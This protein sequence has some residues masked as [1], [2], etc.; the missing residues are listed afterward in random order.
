MPEGLN[1]DQEA[2]N[3]AYELHSS[4]KVGLGESAGLLPDLS[5]IGCS[6]IDKVVA[7]GEKLYSQIKISGDAG[8][9]L[10]NW[11]SEAKKKQ[12]DC[13]ALI[14][15]IPKKKLSKNLF[16]IVIL[17][18]AVVAGIIVSKIFYNEK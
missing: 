9:Q 16:P 2:L 7:N 1:I 15:P 6:S 18:G 13:K 11:M 5:T 3:K 12:E 17:A 4:N 8:Q 10:E 14:T